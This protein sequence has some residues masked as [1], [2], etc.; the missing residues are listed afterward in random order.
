MK[1]YDFITKHFLQ[2][3]Y[4]EK[5]KTVL[6]IANEIDCG[7]STILRKM[8]KYNIKGR[9]HSECQIG[10]QKG[11]NNPRFKDGRYSKKYYCIECGEEISFFS[12]IYGQG[13]CRECWRKFNVGKNNHNYIDGRSFE[14]YPLDWNKN[15]RKQIRERDNYICQI[16]GKN[17]FNLIEKLHIHHIDYNKKNLDPNN[18]I[19][20]CTS[21]HM[22]TNHNRDYWYA[23]LTYL[24][25]GE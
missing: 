4:N 15:F 3:E 7:R 8:K 25:E 1:K 14:P 20:L 24:M 12:G 2:N 23:Y 16:C 6:E 11:K 13:R 10:R 9:N 22:K 21:C 5:A 19:S 17:Q 18:L